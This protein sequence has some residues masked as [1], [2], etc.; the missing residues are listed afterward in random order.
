MSPKER[1]L[2]ASHDRLSLAFHLLGKSAS[3]IVWAFPGENGGQPRYDWVEIEEA[4][5]TAKS[6]CKILANIKGQ[7]ETEQRE[8]VVRSLNGMDSRAKAVSCA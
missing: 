8:T 4:Y 5:R 2:T 7:I 1:I 3:K 6:A